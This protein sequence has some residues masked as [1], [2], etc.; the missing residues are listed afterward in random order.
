[1]RI[2]LPIVDRTKLYSGELIFQLKIA[3]IAMWEGM[4][5]KPDGLAE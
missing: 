4:V 1:M 2:F 5:F 3:L